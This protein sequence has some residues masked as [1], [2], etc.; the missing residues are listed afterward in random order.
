[1]RKKDENYAL[2]LDIGSNSVGWA[3]TGYDY[4]LIK[5]NKQDAWGVI[6]F[7]DAQTAKTRRTFRSARRRLERRRMRIRLLQELMAEGIEPI[8]P[9][10]Y[11]RLKESSYHMGEGKY[12]RGNRY[13]LFD[14]GEYTDVQYYSEYP[15][16]YHLRKKLAESKEKADI[17]LIYLALHHII[18]YRG[19]FLNEGGMDSAGGSPEAA[20][21]ELFE[22]LNENYKKDLFYVDKE[23]AFVQAVLNDK[24]SRSMRQENA[25][26]VLTS[27]KKDKFVTALTKAVVGL[28]ANLTDLLCIEDEEDAIK[29]ENDKPVSIC[30]ADA[31][32]EEEKEDKYY[33]LERADILLAAEKLYAAIELNTVLRGKKL[34][35][36]AMVDK[37]VKHGRDLGILRKLIRM[38][39]DKKLYNGFFRASNGAS[40][41]GY[42]GDKRYGF[43]GGKPDVCKKTTKDE[44]YKRIRE[45]LDKN[46]PDC[47]EKKYV[48][49]EMDKED[50]LPLI[51]SKDNAYIPY[52]LNLKELN[53]ILENQGK[54]HPCL[55]KNADK[56]RALLTFRRP[57]FVGT[58]KGN[59][60]WTEG[61][62]IPAD[63]RIT[64]WNFYEVLGEDN[65][66]KLAENFISRMTNDCI[67]IKGEDALPLNSMLYQKYV[68]LNEINKI[69]VFGKAISVEWKK[70]I[71]ELCKTKK[72]VKKKDIAD[73]LK[74]KFNVQAKEDD[75]SGLSD[76]KKLTASLSTYIEFV[77][78]FKDKGGEE[79]VKAN[80][81]AIEEV[82]RVLTI[83]NDADIRKKRI[84]AMKVFEG[85][86]DR[87]AKKNYSGWGKYSRKALYGTLGNTGKC[88]LDIM[89]E[90]NEHINEVLWKEEYGFK[91]KFVDE[92]EPIE[93]FEYEQVDRMRISPK[94][95]RAV[96]NAVRLAEELAKQIGSDP[97]YI[98]LEDT[99]EIG[100]K[101][102][103]KSRYDKVFEFYKAL[104][105]GEYKDI[106]DEENMKYCRNELAKH[107]ERKSALDEDK[108]YL[109]FIQ[110][111]RSMY[112]G[113]K[114]DIERLNECEIDHIIPRSLIMD[115]SFENRALVWKKEN[116]EKGDRAMSV[117]I[118]KKMRPFWKFLYDNRLIGSKKFT[119]LQKTEITEKDLAGFINRQLVETGYTVSLVKELL[120][121][122]FPQA[123]VR[124]IK[125][126]L[127]STIRKRFA[128]DHTYFNGKEDVTEKGK[129]GF[130]KIRGLNNF[131]H[132]KDA[133]LAC[134]AGL[135]TTYSCP[136]WG[137]SDYNK[138]LNYFI[139]NPE[140]S[141]YNTA[142]AD[143]ENQEKANSKTT[144]TLINKRYCFIVNLMM[145]TERPDL[146]A[147]DEESGEYLWDTDR[148]NNM[149]NTMARNTCHVVK[150][151]LYM[152]KGNFYDQTVYSPD[153][154]KKG[155][156]PLKSHNG[157]DMPTE[158]YGGYSNEEA[159]YFVIVRVKEK[160]KGVIKEKTEF[161]KIPVKIEI[162]GK[163][164]VME[165]IRQ[166]YD[167]EAEIIRP[168]YKYQLIRYRKKPD[169]KG[170]LCYVAGESEL[171]N[172]EEV[173]FNSKFEK[174]LYLCEKSADSIEKV[175]AAD[176]DTDYPA[177]MKEFIE[178]YCY[179]MKLRLPL[180]E[181]FT[182]KLSEAVQN[183]KYDLLTIK[184]KAEL[185]NQLLIISKSGAGRVTLN[186]KLGIKAEVGRLKDKTI[187]PEIVDWIDMP[188]TGLYIHTEKGLK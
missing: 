48:T 96:W 85:Y 84:K 154:S 186:P 39:G 180:F 183:G 103:T 90:T 74:R 30:F 114:I 26:N 38:A 24:V 130:Y 138:A 137:N 164:A 4:N 29:D 21:K 144:A 139:K 32:Y 6:L 115:N 19:H 156:I 181:S 86:E 133:Y 54:F 33:S 163:Q 14:G 60:S 134:V 152:A 167:R 118:V 111:G 8:D 146:F 66:D 108:L 113:T 145:Q 65:L 132:A 89:Y 166:L 179:V 3:A 141:K 87:L 101:K 10:F 47:D 63:K 174:L 36:D 125:P 188:L 170:Q 2:G 57:Y 5:V 46:V 49:D 184:E 182:Q 82:V 177:M 135:F 126:K 59:F 79:F 120:M 168:V 142:G 23:E 161:R 185:I 102:R 128:S 158:F 157:E 124:G 121:R 43:Y 52:Q 42:V 162:Q 41:T 75:I 147:L 83:F 13:N 22:L 123:D 31:K 15:T 64:P 100:E 122:R 116:Q 149:L 127:S 97:K 117:D 78:M 11:I 93:K 56:I 155:L 104:K 160:K 76:E 148:F 55:A 45:I 37:F 136:L 44:L 17:R 80:F 159:G 1:M 72:T 67:L 81:D 53:A 143:N 7:E 175:I 62:D 58:L 140:K 16:V 187:Y 172:A 151:K 69:K 95:K 109:W 119:N 70:E 169:E 176:P 51:T 34:L 40:Y 28:K 171:Q 94:V 173:Y 77:N 131:H 25:Y 91:E 129:A 150:K 20:A 112:S 27:E 50:F 107:K 9:A 61:A 110:L 68:L 105:D 106:I 88:V 18:K 153:S 12:F 92:T 73:R 98:F 35:C 178:H 71:Y 165:Y 99:T